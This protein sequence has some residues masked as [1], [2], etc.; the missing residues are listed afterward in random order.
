LWLLD[1]GFAL[2]KY[3]G[4]ALTAGRLLKLIWE[5]NALVE[6]EK[7]HP[8]F[9]SIQASDFHSR[10]EKE[11]CTISSTKIEH[12]DASQFDQIFHILNDHKSGP[13]KGR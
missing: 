4:T 1:L 3:F 11:E 10:K 5:P 7:R 2:V 13:L 9:D 6:L 8:D 12:N